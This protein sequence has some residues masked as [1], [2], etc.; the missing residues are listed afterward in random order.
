M[1][2]GR[3]VRKGWQPKDNGE[4]GATF[5]KRFRTTQS[6]NNQMRMD[7]LKNIEVDKGYLMRVLIQAVGP[8]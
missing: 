3:D 5:A 2:I 6:A 8:K 7:L 4:N 1:K